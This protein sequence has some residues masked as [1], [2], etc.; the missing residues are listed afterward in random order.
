MYNSLI[1][2]GK[3]INYRKSLLP[4]DDILYVGG[5]GGAAGPV[6]QRNKCPDVE[7]NA[8]CMSPEA[9]CTYQMT[10]DLYCILRSSNFDKLYYSGT[11]ATFTLKRLFITRGVDHFEHQFMSSYGTIILPVKYK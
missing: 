9:T 10:Q 6:P 1:C 8:V 11:C 5:M 3:S 2:Q 7:T 4:S